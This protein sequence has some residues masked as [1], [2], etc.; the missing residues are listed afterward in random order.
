MSPSVDDALFIPDGARF[1]STDLTRG[2]WNEGAQHFGPAAALVGGAVDRLDDTGGVARLTFEILRPLPTVATYAVDLRLAKPGR[3]VQVVD[4]VLTADGVE[5]A[6]ARGLRLRTVDHR[7][8]P[9]AAAPPPP[10]APGTRSGD[11]LPFD[12]VGD[13]R[14]F[15]THG[16]EIAV[17]GG[18][19][20][21]P[22]PA[23]AWFRLRHPVVAGTEPSGVERVAAA[24][25][26]GNGISWALS[27]REFLFMNPD[28]GIHLHRRPVGEWIALDATTVATGTGAGLAESALFDERG[29]IGRSLQ[30]LLVEPR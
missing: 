13:V 10:P 9:E 23:T 12:M 15:H 26:F 14:A 28:L 5:V 8:P 21:E 24:A 16:M 11:G 20:S 1:R 29:G 27:W 19:A 4:A 2:P 22:G 25:D 17:V 30:V 3:R 18:R 6:W 7:V